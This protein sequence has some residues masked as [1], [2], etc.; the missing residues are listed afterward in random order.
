MHNGYGWRRY[1]AIIAAKNFALT[2]DAIFLINIP[3]DT[4]MLFGSAKHKYVRVVVRLLTLQ[5][6]I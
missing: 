2:R 3:N 4:T 6:P 1:T 5:K